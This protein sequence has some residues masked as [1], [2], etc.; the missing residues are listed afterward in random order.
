MNNFKQNMSC[1]IKQKRWIGLLLIILFGVQFIINFYFNV[2]LLGNHMG[3]DSSWS[4]LKA[5][6]IWNEKALNSDIWVDQTSAFLDSSMTL[7][8]LLYGITGNLLV[9]YGIANEIVLVCVLLCIY[10]ILNKLGIN[11]EGRFFALNLVICP[12]LTNGF[13]VGN[14]LGYFNDLISGPAFY[15]LRALIVLMIVREFLVIRKNGKIDVLGYVSLFLCAL[16]GMSSGI[17]IIVMILLPYILYEIE[18]MFIKNDY[19]VLIKVE[20]IYSYLGVALVFC[21]KIFAK[22]VLNISAIDT[23]RTWTPLSKLWTNIGAPFLGFMKLLGVLPVDDTSVSVLSKEG[24]YR[25]FPLFIFF[26]ALLSIG[27]AIKK[28]S[29]EISIENGF[30]HFCLNL[31]FLNFLIFGL[32]NAHYGS[33]L[34]EERYLICTYMIVV[35]LMAYYFQ[36]LDRT[37]I[38][39]QIVSIVLLVSLIGNNFISNKKYVETTNDSWQMADIGAIVNSEDAELVYF[40][41]DEVSVLGRAM[42]VYDLNHVYKEIA[43]SGGYYHWGDY[44]YYEDNGD[45]TGSTILIIPKDSEIVPDNI[46]N[47]YSLIQELDWVLIYKCDYNPIDMVSGFTGKVSVDYP[48]TPGMNVQYG[49]FDGN[50]YISDGTAG[51]VMF[52]PFCTTKTG[53]YDFKL[54]YQI[55]KGDSATFDVAID[56]GTM[57]LGSCALDNSIQEVT[58]SNVEIEE[59]HTLEYRVMCGEGTEIKINKVTIVRKD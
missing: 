12:Y 30:I 39:T 51:Y 42:R 56:S 7:A 16:A 24:I 20:A 2:R 28:L 27:Y 52:G 32:F 19:K 8:S 36:N 31:V 3:L 54:D 25:L 44:K 34:F 1:I 4:Y 9:S 46:L 21:G 49:N 59:G 41:G 5:T 11:L 57:Q 15:S 58:I 53:K 33:A 13:D 17:F 26:V 35:I 37:L 43:S 50:S 23:T 55:L 40:W 18:C 48:S 38:F 14:D 22:H 47:Q 6:L 10:S 45:Y 29:K